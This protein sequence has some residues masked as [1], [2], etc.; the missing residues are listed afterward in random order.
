MDIDATREV[1]DFFE[2]VMTPPNPADVDGDGR[3]DGADLTIV[4]GH[5]GDSG[6][7]CDLDGNGVVDGG[8]LTIVLGSWDGDGTDP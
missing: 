6:S 3:V 8:D 4:L 7:P 2:W 5:W 1:W